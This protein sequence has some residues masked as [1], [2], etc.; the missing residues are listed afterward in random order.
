MRREPSK[1]NQTRRKPAQS[2]GNGRARDRP[3]AHASPRREAGRSLGDIPM[4]DMTKHQAVLDHVREAQRRRRP[5]RAAISNR[6]AFGYDEG[7]F[8]KGPRGRTADTVSTPA[9][10]RTGND[11]RDPFGKTEAEVIRARSGML[12]TRRGGVKKAATDALRDVDGLLIP[13]G[14]DFEKGEGVKESRLEF[15][16]AL[17]RTARDMG[18]PTLG[19]CGGSRA[20][21]RAF[22]GV[23][24]QLEGDHGHS[25]GT[26][27]VMG[28][29]LDLVPHTILGGSR[30]GSVDKINSTHEK[31][32]DL[33]SVSRLPKR[34][35]EAQPEPELRVS[36]RST[37]G[38]IEGFETPHGAPIVGV[39]S[40]PEAIHG[41]SSKAVSNASW[42]GKAWSDEVILA[43]EQAM[44]TYA[45]RKQVNAHVRAFAAM[46]LEESKALEASG[47]PTAVWGQGPPMRL[48]DKRSGALRKSGA[49]AEALG[50]G[51]FDPDDMSSLSSAGPSSV[52]T[53]QL[54]PTPVQSPTGAPMSWAARVA[55][56]PPTIQPQRATTPPNPAQRTPP[57]TGGTGIQKSTRKPTPSS[58]PAST[59]HGYNNRGGGNRGAGGGPRKKW[60]Q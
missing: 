53:A 47:V 39:T 34:P 46:R 17:V 19:Y 20:V 52:T 14:Q 58:S 51:P 40:H 8:L 35:R 37:D 4:F 2:N 9:F 30:G 41:A 28:H 54:S 60:D 24:K 32:V 15:E 43:H 23:E 16:P 48:S 55:Q 44:Q 38:E 57:P 31:V 25:L 21:A 50:N 1:R 42:Q 18:M 56:G 22:G 5:P 36:A 59:F 45:S 26:T 27:D 7:T 33:S 12:V 10:D 49:L 3:A 11:S 29:G 6:A 13:G